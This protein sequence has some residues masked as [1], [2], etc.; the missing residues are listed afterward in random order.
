MNYE[1]YSKEPSNE[2][3]LQDESGAGQDKVQPEEGEKWK[4]SRLI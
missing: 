2:T 1:N 3:T 4:I